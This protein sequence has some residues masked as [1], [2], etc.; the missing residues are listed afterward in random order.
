MKEEVDSLSTNSR[1]F[2]SAREEVRE[3]P[4]IAWLLE[5]GGERGFA[6]CVSIVLLFFFLSTH[7]VWIWYFGS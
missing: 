2:S 6:E 7:D 3:D 1:D 4:F 5:S